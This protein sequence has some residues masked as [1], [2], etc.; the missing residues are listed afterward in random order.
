MAWLAEK[1]KVTLVLMPC[2][3]RHLAAL[4]PSRVVGSLTTTCLCQ[5]AY[6]WASLHMPPAS[7]AITSVLT[8]PLAISQISMMV[9]LKGLPSFATNEGLVVTPSRMPSEAASR[10]SAM[11][12][13]STKNF[14][15]SS[16]HLASSFYSADLHSRFFKV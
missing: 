3:L 7:V 11:L 4:R 14:I 12:A 6:S 10:I 5:L 9:C 16:C 8:G 13:V 15:L 1:H 2:S